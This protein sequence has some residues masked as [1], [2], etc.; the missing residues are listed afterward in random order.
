MKI[1]MNVILPAA[2]ASCLIFGLNGCASSPK[3]AAS[4]GAAAEKAERP[5]R[6]SVPEAEKTE[7][8]IFAERLQ[9]ALAEDDIE[10]ALA[11]FDGL[12]EQ[13]ADD[14]D[15]EML[16]ASLL[17][18][19]GRLDDAGKAVRQLAEKNAGN[20]EILELNAQLAIASGDKKAQQAALDKLLAADPRNA[21]ANIIKGNQYALAK[22]YKLAAQS[23]KKALDAEPSNEDALF[24]Y[25]QMSYYA[26]NVKAA[27]H[28]LKRLLDVN[29]ENSMALCYLGKLAAEDEN[30][31][32]ATQ[33]IERAIAIDGKNYDFYI[34]YGTYLRYR[35]KFD[36]AEAAWTKA[37]S[38]LP[39][40]FLAY[41]Y[42]A[43]LYDERGQFQK[44]LADYRKVVQTNPK[45]YFAYEEMGI[46]EFHEGDWA[47]A[48]KAFLKAN[49][50]SASAAYQ[51][52]IAATYLKEKNTF[53]AK[54][55]AQA[56]M[57]GMGRDTL[58]YKMMRMY[59][60]QGGANAENALAKDLEKESDR[61]KRG[62]MMYYFA[63]YYELKGYQQLARDY[64]EK[65]VS[66]KSPMFFEYRL[67][68]WGIGR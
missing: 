18:S 6:T 36:D 61:N 57:K 46:L 9:A 43:G 41:A 39:D 12:P 24:G 35:G 59:H 30:Y 64:Y 3:P 28:T 40:Y 67:A 62:R 52:M 29:P 56:A 15:L 16:R 48:R 32:A 42:R 44:A 58:E 34:D 7:G 8:V 53:E 27:E 33:Y 19:A 1:N 25:G 10:A 23:Y 47:A 5:A 4:S 60:D 37:V 21:S 17:I 14:A 26:G 65:V 45:Y 54:K 66:M 22:K 20:V 68:E 31:L 50:I 11:Y 63:L 13:L 55:Y 51:L 2:A 49:E 38:L